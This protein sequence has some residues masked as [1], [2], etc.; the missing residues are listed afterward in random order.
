MGLLSKS[1]VE[2]GDGLGPS[3]HIRKSGAQH[4]RTEGNVVLPPLR[5]KQ[6]ISNV[7]PPLRADRCERHRP[8][9][10]AAAQRIEPN[11]RREMQLG[12]VRTCTA[13]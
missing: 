7:K 3:P 9:D 4:D 11:L 2:C 13:P 12:A 5:Q 8:Q 6:L 1:L 10:Y